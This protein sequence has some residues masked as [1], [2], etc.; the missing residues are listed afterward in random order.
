MS[1]TI[2]VDL[3]T[4]G[5]SEGAVILS[6][7]MVRFD[8]GGEFSANDLV[9]QSIFVKFDVK[10]Q[11]EQYG[12]KVEKSTVE[13]WSKQP[14]VTRQS[15]F[16]P[17]PTDLSMKDGIDVL[18]KWISD[19]GFK[20][21]DVV[22]MRGAMDHV[23]LESMCKQLGR[24]MPYTDNRVRDIRTAIDIL[25]DSNTG[26]CNTSKPDTVHGRPDLVPHHPVFDC[27]RDVMQLRYGVSA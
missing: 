14:E 2:V 16:V 17:H 21:S 25:Y 1:V 5:L 3:E 10:N 20:Q 27:I 23:W 19:S 22:F 11:V 24:P 7:G 12:R 6:A 13:W 18:A 4:L 8:M 26:C 9:N 15:Q